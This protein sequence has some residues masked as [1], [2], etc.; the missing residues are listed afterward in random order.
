MANVEFWECELKKA[1]R[2]L[3]AAEE[4]REEAK[5]CQNY[6]NAI[7]NHFVHK[8]GKAVN[9]YDYDVWKAEDDI[10]NAKKKIK[11]E[12]QREREEKTQKQKGSSSSS[13]SSSHSSSSSSISAGEAIGKGIGAVGA[14]G[15]SLVRSGAEKVR[16]GIE[17]AKDITKE[18]LECTK[19]V[20]KYEEELERK[21]P[22]EDATEEDIKR[23]LPELEA[24]SKRLE[25]IC[26]KQEDDDD[27]DDDDDDNF[28][29]S[30][31]SLASKGLNNSIS[32]DCKD[33]VDE[34]Y[35]KMHKKYKD[36]CAERYRNTL[37]RK[38]PV[39]S[40]TDTELA[41]WLPLL[42]SEIEL[43]EKECKKSK[44]N[45]INYPIYCEY[46]QLASKHAKQVGNKLKGK[47]SALYNSPE[48]QSAAKKINTNNGGG[49]TKTILKIVF[50]PYYLIYLL[51]TWPFK[52][53]K[54]KSNEK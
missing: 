41:A 10:K 47:N 49:N 6:K 54:S 44:G 18:A 30:M 19:E 52:M 14:A 37:N 8:L 7:A 29:F 12:K 24:E 53:M 17:V 25:D 50:F 11:E 31:R 16:E 13:S 27:D 5:K 39:D 1:E 45:K 46:K 35:E 21:Y 32:E 34:L 28:D 43:Q 23:W 38:Y 15:V 48:I 20:E 40:A 2:R 3:K 36:L 33:V 42:L 51:F 22:I 9:C 4:S 26:K